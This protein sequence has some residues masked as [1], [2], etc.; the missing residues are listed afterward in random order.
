MR[1]QE[2][3]VSA[4]PVHGH[5][6]WHLGDTPQQSCVGKA[7]RAIGISLL[8]A[9]VSAILFALWT[10]PGSAGSCFWGGLM[11]PGL[12]LDPLQARH[13][14]PSPQSLPPPPPITTSHLLARP[15]KFRKHP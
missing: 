12:K 7:G 5:S 6:E 15:T 11:V 1:G 4:Q 2:A 13:V 3:P 9:L 10:Q 14:P 8:S